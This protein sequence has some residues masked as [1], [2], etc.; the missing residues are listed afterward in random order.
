MVGRVRSIL[1]CSSYSLRPTAALWCL[2]GCLVGG[3]VGGLIGCG[4]RGPLRLAPASQAT[5]PMTSQ[6]D[7]RAPNATPPQ[8]IQAI[9]LRLE[10]SLQ[11]GQNRP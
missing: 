7:S 4:Q 9:P 3:S 5:S 11:S 8:P 1:A 10:P 6:T 2:V